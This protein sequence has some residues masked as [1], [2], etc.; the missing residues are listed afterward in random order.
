[1]IT[2]I[3]IVLVL[4]VGFILW[5]YSSKKWDNQDLIE[6]MIQSDKELAEARDKNSSHSNSAFLEDLRIK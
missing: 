1:M 4:I 3:S 5:W 2:I 6:K